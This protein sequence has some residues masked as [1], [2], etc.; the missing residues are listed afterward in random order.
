[1]YKFV[2]TE[3]VARGKEV[4][5]KAWRKRQAERLQELGAAI[6]KVYAALGREA[7]RVFVEM[8]EVETWQEAERI[9]AMLGTDEVLQALE[10]ERAG[11]GMVVEGSAELYIL[12]DY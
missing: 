10:D 2:L 5:D 4:E 12:V 3:I 9:S 1:M 11:K 7:G 8:G 6:P